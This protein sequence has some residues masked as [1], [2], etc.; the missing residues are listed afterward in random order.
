[1]EPMLGSGSKVCV[2]AG[3]AADA[4]A[5]SQ[6]FG[7]SWLFAYRGIIPHLHLDSMIR[8]R[9]P[10]WWRSAVRSGDSTLVLEHAGKLVGYATFGAARQRGPSQGEIYELYL[11]PV[12]QGVGFGEH[13]FEGCRHSAT[14]RFRT[15]GPD[16][17]KSRRTRTH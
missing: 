1:M 13:L 9:T 5:L 4:A 8:Q 2:R 12:C 6:V 11:D 17:T 15:R 3:K 16:S 7:E 14:H 10:E